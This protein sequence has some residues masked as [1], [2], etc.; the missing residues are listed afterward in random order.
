MDWITPTIAAAG[1]IASAGIS[2]GSTAVKNKKS[3]KYT[4]QLTD[5]QNTINQRNWAM[6]NYYNSPSQQ[7]ARLKAAGL[8]PNLVYQQGGATAGAGEIGSPNSSQFDY[9]SPLQLPD[10]GQ[11][12]Q[13]F[14]VANADIE[15]T[16][17]D[18]ISKQT[19]NITKIE[20]SKY[21][22]REAKAYIRGL[23]LQN[24]IGEQQ[25][26]LLSA[27]TGLTTAQTQEAVLNWSKIPLE[28]SKL[29]SEIRLTDKQFEHLNAVIENVNSNTDLV[30]QQ[31]QKGIVELSLSNMRLAAEQK[32]DS[33]TFELMIQHL[34]QE[35]EKLSYEN[36]EEWRTYQMLPDNVESFH[37]GPI[38]Y[39]HNMKST[40]AKLL[41]AIRQYR[42]YKERK[43]QRH[44]SAT[45]GSW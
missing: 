18:T 3:Y 14:R 44:R 24:A 21:A 1:T 5:Y 31:Y 40:E 42:R 35:V 11:S 37:I 19:D 30:R 28:M 10:L 43:T 45:S 27:Q 29:R 4:K 16:V 15:N 23:E 12:F 39:S 32:A 26:L 34:S 41:N 6:Q 7:M 38:S 33:N 17:A 36:S 20:K 25:K 2:A 9:E 22:S 13:A 8:N